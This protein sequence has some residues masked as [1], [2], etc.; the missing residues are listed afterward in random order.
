MNGYTQTTKGDRRES[1]G[2]TTTAAAA[3]TN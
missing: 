1:G 2:T 3:D